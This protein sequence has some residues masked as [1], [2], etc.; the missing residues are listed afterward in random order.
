MFPSQKDECSHVAHPSNKHSMCVWAHTLGIRSD[1]LPT[2][3]VF[4]LMSVSKACE[5][6]V[7]SFVMIEGG[8]AL[9]QQA[10]DDWHQ[11][12]S[13]EGREVR[14]TLHK[15][16][17]VTGNSLPLTGKGGLRFPLESRW[18]IICGLWRGFYFKTEF[19]SYRQEGEFW[20]WTPLPVW[21]HALHCSLELSCEANAPRRAEEASEEC[22]RVE[23]LSAPTAWVSLSL[24]D[25][26]TPNELWG[27]VRGMGG[28]CQE[29]HSS[30]ATVQSL[31]EA[32]AVKES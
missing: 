32:Q 21:R 26:P 22:V 25:E 8:Q 20:S 28:V 9:E 27:G 16:Y 29:L 31:D 13:E 18:R 19:Q 23:S 12:T 11:G 3:C 15:A 30:S 6:Q 17:Q 1:W 2:K 24:S 4:L 10:N 5:V 7:G 14:G